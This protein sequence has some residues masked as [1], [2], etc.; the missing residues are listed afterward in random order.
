MHRLP[1][2][3][4]RVG[5]RER[6]S[7]GAAL[8]RGVAEN[9]NCNRNSAD[10]AADSAAYELSRRLPKEAGSVSDAP[11]R[12]NARGSRRTGGRVFDMARRDAAFRH[13]GRTVSGERE[14]QAC[15]RETIAEAPQRPGRS[16]WAPARRDAPA[17]PAPGGVFPSS[18]SN[19][20]RTSSM[21][22]W[23]DVMS[24]SPAPRARKKARRAKPSGRTSEHHLCRLFTICSP[25]SQ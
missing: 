1:V 18:A 8:F 24:P 12:T 7:L 13:G 3:N 5:K 23:I 22:A 25:K 11:P 21:N 16:S 15:A 9:R 20:S 10:F 17:S 19:A 6:G 4:Q 14:P 2:W